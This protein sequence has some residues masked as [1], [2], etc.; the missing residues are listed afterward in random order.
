MN[1]YYIQLAFIPLIFCSSVFISFCLEKL[2]L[3][4]GCIRLWS[5]GLLA[6]YASNQGQS[7]NGL[8]LNQPVIFYECMLSCL[9]SVCSLSPLVVFSLLQYCNGRAVL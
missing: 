9:R 8:G 1:Q 5:R 3:N 2:N 4:Y 6:L 7:S